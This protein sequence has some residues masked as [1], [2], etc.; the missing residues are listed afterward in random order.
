MLPAVKAMVGLMNKDDTEMINMF[1]SVEL[2]INHLDELIGVFDSS[3]EGGD[4]C[5]GL[6]F[7]YSGSNLLFKI[8][9]EIITRNITPTPKNS[10]N[11]KS[12][13]E[14]NH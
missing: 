7:G 1:D 6:T 2:F 14:N 4:F 10:N 11:T 8:A 5:A 9:E 3:Y 13:I 12:P